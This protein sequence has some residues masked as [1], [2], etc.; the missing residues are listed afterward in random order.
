MLAPLTS[1]PNAFTAARL[2][3]ANRGTALLSE[4]LNSNT[5]NLVAGLVVPGLLVTVLSLTPEAKFEFA[6]LILMTVASL[7]ML[8]RP[9]GVRRIDGAVLIG[10]TSSSASSR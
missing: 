5:I 2:G 6:W 7:L 9:R 10:S 8:S 4:T 3:L 1:I